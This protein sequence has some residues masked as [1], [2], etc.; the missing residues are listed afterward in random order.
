[1]LY[2]FMNDT[3]EWLETYHMRSISETAN[4]IIKWKMP[5][6]TKKRLPRRKRTEEYLK[7]NAHNL[8]Q[9]KTFS[10]TQIPNYR[11]IIQMLIRRNFVP[12]PCLMKT[13]DISSQ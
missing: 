4:S 10:G 8:R 7:I 3:Q 9:F 5:F 2:A 13:L 1:M 6:K 12:R 11:K